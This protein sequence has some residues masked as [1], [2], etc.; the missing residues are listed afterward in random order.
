MATWLD[1]L[2]LVL[3]RLS[4]VDGLSDQ[5]HRTTQQSAGAFNQRFL[6][7]SPDTAWNLARTMAYP[8]Q[9]RVG[10]GLQADRSSI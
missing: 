4:D 5:E 9:N 6:S 8:D 1:T 7:T 3:S 2:Q 10:A